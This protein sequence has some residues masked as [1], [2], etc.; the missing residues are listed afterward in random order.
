MEGGEAAEPRRESSIEVEVVEFDGD[1][2]GVG[3]TCNASPVT[4]GG[5]EV[6][7]VLLDDPTGEMVVGI[8]DLILFDSEE[9]GAVSGG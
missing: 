9:D 8:M 6:I 7:V 2:R 1:N 4:V 5:S 3:V